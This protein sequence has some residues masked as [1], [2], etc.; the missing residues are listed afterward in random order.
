MVLGEREAIAWLQQ[1]KGVARDLPTVDWR[2]KSAFGLSLLGSAAS[3]ADGFG[4]SGL[5]NF[6]KRS[7]LAGAAS[8]PE[9][10]AAG[11]PPPSECDRGARRESGRAAKHR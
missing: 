1:D 7:E 9:G 5:A 4:L 10:A 11:I 6:M 2:P 3:I 8:G